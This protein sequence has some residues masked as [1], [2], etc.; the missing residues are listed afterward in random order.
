MK[1]KTMIATFAV[2]VGGLLASGAA[3]A[4]AA[5]TFGLVKRRSKSDA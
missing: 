4:Q 2:C 5:P 1:A 3:G